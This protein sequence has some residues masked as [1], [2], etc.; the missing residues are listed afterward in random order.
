MIASAAIAR[1][2]ENFSSDARSSSCTVCC[3]RSRLRTY[4]CCTPRSAS[5]APAISDGMSRSGLRENS[6]LQSHLDVI[7]AMRQAELLL[8]AL[9]VSI[10]RLRADEELLTNLGRGVTLRHETQH[11]ALALRELVEPL[12][13]RGSGILLRKIPRQ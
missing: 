3:S 2:P 13:L 11:V 10:H 9:L 12:S 1:I 6:E 7:G 8:N 5:R 4:H